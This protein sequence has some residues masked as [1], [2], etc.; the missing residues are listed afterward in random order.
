M[1]PNVVIIVLPVVLGLVALMTL[2]AIGAHR[3]GRG[4]PGSA[5][6][7]VFFPVTWAA[8]YVRDEHPYRRARRVLTHEH[9]PLP[10]APE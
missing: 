9:R 3:R 5:A 10:H 7:G 4:L 6:A 8:W 2:T 1:D